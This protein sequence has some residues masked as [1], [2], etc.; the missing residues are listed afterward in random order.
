LSQHAARKCGCFGPL[1]MESVSTGRDAGLVGPQPPS[2]YVP[3]SQA[4]RTIE[5]VDEQLSAAFRMPV[6]EGKVF[7]FVPGA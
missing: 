7:T 3:V 2:E 4:V 5:V 6:R 1:L